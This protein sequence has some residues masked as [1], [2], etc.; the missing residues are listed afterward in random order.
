MIKHIL[1]DGKVEVGIS[2]INDGNMRFFGEG[3]ESKII[4]NQREFGNLMGLS[5][6]VRVRTIYGERKN[7]TEYAEITKENSSEYSINNFEEEIPISDG[8]V[9]RE[10]EVGILLPLADCLGVVAFDKKQKIIGLLHSGRQNIEQN[11]PKKF[12]E[13]FMNTFKSNASDLKI[14]CSPYALD[15]RI[16]KLDKNLG[17]A[18]KEQ[19]VDAGVLPDNIIDSKVDTVSSDCFPSYSSGDA[20]RRFAIVVKQV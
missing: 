16:F 7:F 2:E 20:N 15:Y 10:T 19:F 9:T 12:I 14:Y 5:N 1:F 6:V 18:T 11:G 8:L 3:D 13:Y 4:K 17:E